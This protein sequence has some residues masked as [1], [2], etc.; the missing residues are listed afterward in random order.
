MLCCIDEPSAKLQ[1]VKLW[2]SYLYYFS[3]VVAFELKS[4]TLVE[5]RSRKA[6]GASRK[7][8]A[9]NWSNGVAWVA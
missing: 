9:M 3:S 7:V 8:I 1:L 6:Y 4:N 5:G 2:Y